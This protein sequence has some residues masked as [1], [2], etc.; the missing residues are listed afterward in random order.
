MR[1]L[2]AVGLWTM[3]SVATP[4]SPSAA[5]LDDWGRLRPQQPRAADLLAEGAY[6]SASLRELVARIEQSDVFVY[7]TLDPLMPRQLAG[8]LTW[9][10]EAGRFR[11]LRAS[12]NP[13]QV[14]EA[15]I[16]TIA[17]ELQHVVEV[18]DSPEVRSDQTLAALYGRIGEPSGLRTEASFETAA[19]KAM[20]RT[21]RRELS[22][23]AT[24]ATL[25]LEQGRQQR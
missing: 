9:M 5:A 23:A 1:C 17:H 3:I 15:I 14:P 19:A 8:R 22:L 13:D 16:A 21:V 12:I 11:Y 4:A 20:G 18:I 25:R 10:T 6:R 7:L 2:L 24:V